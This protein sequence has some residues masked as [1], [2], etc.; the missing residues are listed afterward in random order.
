M[1]NIN[2]KSK[3]LNNK[4][5]YSPVTYQDVIVAAIFTIKVLIQKAAKLNQIINLL[6]LKVIGNEHTLRIL[7]KKGNIELLPKIFTELPYEYELYG[8]HININTTSIKALSSLKEISEFIYHNNKKLGATGMA[9]MVTRNL[10]KGTFN[11]KRII[12]RTA[13]ELDHIAEIERHKWLE[14]WPYLNG[15]PFNFELKLTKKFRSITATSNVN[16]MDNE[17]VLEHFEYKKKVYLLWKPI[18]VQLQHEMAQQH[19]IS[20]YKYQIQHAMQDLQEE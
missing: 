4:M 2:S 12:L 14:N 3:V 1:I 7:G 19:K 10:R 8:L 6:Q 15:T 18:I 11:S 13:A 16:K 17:K 20:I 9:W 5:T